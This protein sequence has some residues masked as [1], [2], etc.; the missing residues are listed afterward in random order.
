MYDVVIIGGGPAGLSAGINVRARNK[1]ALV[2]TN[3]PHEG[4]LSKAPKME[5]YL[6]LPGMTGPEMVDTFLAHA[7]SAGVEIRQGRV[8]TV[9]PFGENF[10]VTVGSDV[11]DCKAVI[12]GLG[13]VPPTQFPGEKE[14]L[15]RGV[16][17]CATCDG[18]LYREQPVVVVGGSA[19][20]VNDA[21]YL[22][23]I[24]CDVVFASRKPVEGLPEGV[25]PIIAKK[26][27]VEGDGMRATALIADGERYEGN[28]V[29]ILRE[30]IAPGSLVDG[31]EMDGAFIKVDRGMRTNI[32]RVYAAG[33]CTG[34][35]KQIAKAVGEGLIAG[36]SAC[37]DIG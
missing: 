16:S 10:M 18:M 28:C 15:G 36:L 8:L 3:D 6:G 11:V 13:A 33:D 25:R 22:A 37:E 7:E 26:Y 17:Y 23:E 9:M 12:L 34:N 20:S 31:L 29:F 21:K 32:P 24:G 30:A 5:N 19:E 27:E 14:Y 4:Y 35:P 1:T 2:I